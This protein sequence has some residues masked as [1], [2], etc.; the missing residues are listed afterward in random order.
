MPTNTRILF[1]A[2][3]RKYA[4]D[5]ILDIGSCDG[6]DSLRFRRIFPAADIFAFEANPYLYRAMAANAALA[7]NQIAVFPFAISNYRGIGRFH[8]TDLNYEDAGEKNPGTSSL[9]VREDLKIQ[10]TVDAQTYRI[11]EFVLSHCPKARRV[12]LWIDVEGAELAVLEGMA[13]I[14]D[15]VIAVHV[16]T[17]RTPMRRGQKVFSEV[18]K[19]M[20]SCG[21]IFFGT[22]MSSTSTWG[23]VVFAKRELVPSS[24]S[25]FIFWRAL[26]KLSYCS[27]GGKMRGFL[28]KE[29]SPLYRFYER[30]FR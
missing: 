21:F 22:N 23:D 8:V 17:A 15:R 30:L 28:H 25:R 3:L 1:K 2:L 4:V 9:L 7:E 26:A 11:D 19:F 14:K 20:Q 12:G 5:C 6:A 16:E 18:E 29:S 27:G 10:E 13:G 24:W